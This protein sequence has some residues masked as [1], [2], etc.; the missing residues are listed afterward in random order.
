MTTGGTGFAPRTVKTTVKVRGK[1]GAKPEEREVI[2]R[3]LWLE[4]HVSYDTGYRSE[5]V[6][7]GRG[8]RPYVIAS[9]SV[10]CAESDERARQYQWE[11]TADALWSAIVQAAEAKN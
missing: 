10:L 1:D 4:P 8:R 2:Q 5:F 6:P 11:R 9:V 3:R 7:G